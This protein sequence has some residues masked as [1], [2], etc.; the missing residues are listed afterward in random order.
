MKTLSILSLVLFISLTA[1][2][3]GVGINQQSLP[4][5][6][7]AM[8]DI[9]ST[10]KGLLIPRMR[11]IERT[12]IG[13]PAES[14]LV[15][16]TDTKSFW[17]FNQSWK[18]IVNAGGG[19]GF[20][21][22]YIGSY[23]DPDK[24]FSITNPSAANSG[25]AIH[26]KRSS[27]GSGLVFNMT[28][29]VW[30]DNS[31]G[32]GV[33]GSSDTY[34]GVAGFS[35]TGTGVSAISLEGT[36]LAAISTT[37]MAITGISQ[38]NFGISGTSNGADKPGVL[39]VNTGSVSNGY[40]VIGMIENPTNG[41]AVWG[42]NSSIGGNAGL[43]T[44]TNAANIDPSLK[45]STISNGPAGYFTTSGS[46]ASG[47]F[48]TTG[49][50]HAGYFTG[51]NPANNY[52]VV[53]V[54]NNT[55][56][57]T[58]LS[59][60]QGPTTTTHGVY[61]N[62]QGSGTSIFSMTEMGRA[63]FFGIINAG[64]D[65]SALD[66]STV[67]MGNAATFTKNN[68]G[69]S[70]SDDMKPAVF[71]D[72]NSKGAALK[73]VSPHSPS[74]NS[75]IDV[76]YGGDAF[77]IN[78]L[79]SKK[80]AIHARANNLYPSIYAENF[81]GGAAIK[82]LANGFDTAAIYGET[83]GSFGTGVLGITT[84]S[85]GV[86]VRGI[87]SF[88]LYGAVQGENS[89][90]G[91]GVVGVSTGSFGYGVIGES[92]G[93]GIAGRFVSNSPTAGTNT[94]WVLDYSL[95]ES[96][97][98]QSNNE[99]NASSTLRVVQEGTGNLARFDNTNGE[100]VSISNAGNIKTQG[101]V[102]VKNNKG[103]VRNSSSTQMRVETFTAATSAPGGLDLGANQFVQIPATFSTAFSSAP[104]VYVGHVSG[105]SGDV[106]WLIATVTNVTTTGCTLSLRNLSSQTITFNGTWHLVAMGAE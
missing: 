94:L 101:T 96:F 89:G 1:Q 14:L 68:T 3:Q 49:T 22:P 62:G 23:A 87:S 58:G 18:E 47:Y 61:V 64:N 27:A 97:R 17:Y 21:L 78:V 81:N 56:S 36:A 106:T 76:S 30:G 54:N 90:S 4:A 84:S 42:K 34:F 43:F 85:L 74:N 60:L 55:S 92:N 83:S 91:G 93:Q 41:A 25:V 45:V 44:N 59:V 66:V 77:G 100:R 72:N 13:S 40:G 15:F 53:F 102:T 19:G 63:G 69:G 5:D 103:I 37:G 51:T 8:L 6:A 46:G 12:A 105:G 80:G 95:G 104:V 70:I 28:M 65:K 48:T 29:G 38:T 2:S 20:T 57:G 98:V 75:G 35:N 52:P 82:A 71:I 24:V 50:G 33:V 39:G 26:G 67:G 79:S 86:G 11:T 9:S 16:D 73:I 99:N 7:S 32:A 88:D 10:S 31:T